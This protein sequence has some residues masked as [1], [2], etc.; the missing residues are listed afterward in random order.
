MTDKQKRKRR[1][2]EPAPYGRSAPA[3]HAPLEE[4]LT[5]PDTPENVARTMF[6]KRLLPDGTWHYTEEGKRRKNG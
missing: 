4:D 1:S 6:G 2:R 3:S 5:I